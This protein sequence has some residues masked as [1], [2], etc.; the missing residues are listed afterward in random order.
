[1]PQGVVGKIN[2]NEKFGLYSFALKNQDGWHS[3]GEHPPTFKEG[4]SIQFDSVTK[5]KYNYA[6]NV[7]PWVD[8]GAAQA[9]RVNS[10]SNASNNSGGGYRGGRAKSFGG[11]SDEEKLYWSKKDATQE[12]VQKKIEIQA[13]RNAAIETAKFLYE[14]DLVAKPKAKGEQYDAF[15]ALV[16]QIAS[17]YMANTEARLGNRPADNTSEEPVHQEPHSGVEAANEEGWD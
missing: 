1:M 14:A 7:T 6:Q 10:F 15:L 12:L 3:L 11:K 16:D 2:H 5:G 13:A 17:D 8:G 9:P 4:D